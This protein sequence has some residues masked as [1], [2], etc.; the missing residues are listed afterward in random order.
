MQC[1]I[2]D[3]TTDIET[4]IQKEQIMTNTVEFP[5]FDLDAWFEAIK[6]PK[7][8]VNA[9]VDAQSKNT[10]ALVKAHQVA[11]E[12]YK[13]VAERQVELA[14]ETYESI[15]KK[16]N[17]AFSGKTPEVNAAKQME[18]AQAAYETAVANARELAE[19]AAKVNQDAVTVIS[20]RFNE[21]L[22]EFRTAVNG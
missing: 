10:E 3:T 19:L 7:F 16:V 13:A 1:N 18:F 5:K 9:L 21:S 22:D 11:Y 6:A 17:E 2:T 14:K 20:E 12:G 8:D 15:S 4:D